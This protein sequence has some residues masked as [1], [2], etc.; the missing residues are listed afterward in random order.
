MTVYAYLLRIVTANCKVISELAF[1]REISQT[2]E[3]CFRQLPLFQNNY[4]LPTVRWDLSYCVE[5]CV[6][7]TVVHKVSVRRSLSDFVEVFLTNVYLQKYWAVIALSLS[8][9]IYQIMRPYV[10]LKNI[11]AHKH[12]ALIVLN[13]WRF[14]KNLGFANNHASVGWVAAGFSFNCSCIVRLWLLVVLP[15]MGCHTKHWWQIMHQCSILA[16]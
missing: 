2:V 5:T 6:M 10:Y 9:E 16:G 11:R 14:F 12:W 4:V 8:V 1:F 7:Q 15:Q 3:T 13:I